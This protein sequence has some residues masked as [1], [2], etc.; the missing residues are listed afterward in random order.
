MGRV[1]GYVYLQLYSVGNGVDV[2]SWTIR[3][4]EEKLDCELMPR[5]I[6]AYASLPLQASSG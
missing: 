3:I 4:D 5:S 1:D 2:W 6:Q